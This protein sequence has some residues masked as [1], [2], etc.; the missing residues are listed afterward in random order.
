ML[1]GGRGGDATLAAE[2]AAT[3]VAVYAAMC[4]S[5]FSRV[6]GT[7]LSPRAS[8]RP[9]CARRDD[10]I[11]KRPSTNNAIRIPSPTVY[12]LLVIVITWAG[13]DGMPRLGFA[14]RACGMAVGA[15]GPGAGLAVIGVGCAA[16]VDGDGVGVT[17]GVD[18]VIGGGLIGAGVTVG[19]GV[20]VGT[21]V[22]GVG[23]T[24][25]GATATIC[26]F[27][28]SVAAIAAPLAAVTAAPK[29]VDEGFDAFS[30][31]AVPCGT[32]G[33]ATTGAAAPVAH[34]N[35]VCSTSCTRVSQP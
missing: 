32:A 15:T 27:A 2:T 34:A 17:A 25:E 3:C 21:D 16:G 29:A 33:A 8:A 20:V 7:G 22:T 23:V 26:P 5:S 24:A 19:D 18:G 30:R 35:A 9:V 12:W 11:M 6:A 14:E 1:A 28:A 13:C 10:N 31:S 4:F